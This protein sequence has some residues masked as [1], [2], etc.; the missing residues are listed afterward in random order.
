LAATAPRSTDVD[1][2]LV[3]PVEGRLVVKVAD[4]L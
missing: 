4:E 1:V 3:L 2:E